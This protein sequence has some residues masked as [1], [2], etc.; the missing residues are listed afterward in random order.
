MGDVLP[1]PACPA[2]RALILETPLPT[3][4]PTC[5][6]SLGPSAE[7]SP[8]SAQA[9]PTP[10]GFSGVETPH[11]FNGLR[12]PVQNPW[13]QG[14]T[15]TPLP[16]SIDTGDLPP[17]TPVVEDASDWPVAD[18]ALRPV[19]SVSPV[20]PRPA[21]KPAPMIT[22][23][24]L[25]DDLELTPAEL[26]IVGAER[27]RR[28]NPARP[29]EARKLVIASRTRPMSERL[30]RDNT[31]GLH[32]DLAREVVAGSPSWVVRGLSESKANLLVAKLN[33]VGVQSRAIDPA[34]LEDGRSPRNRTYA[35]EVALKLSAAVILFLFLALLL[36][37]EYFSP[38]VGDWTIA[39]RAE[40][41]SAFQ[42]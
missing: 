9:T 33:A 26:L 35:V 30:I 18:P 15:P 3:V 42:P 17:T 37:A 34:E 19:V 14:A 4:C 29:T 20:M 5:G 21:P 39:L 12:T 32:I 38:L 27:T 40:V 7:P 22:R 13:A 10:H 6:E 16:W 36:G 1:V 24:S 8:W 23:E 28:S 25:F 41:V 31:V 11:G 2:C